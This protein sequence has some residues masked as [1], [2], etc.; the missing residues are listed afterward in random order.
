MRCSSSPGGK[1]IWIRLLGNTARQGGM[2]IW[3]Y[4]ANRALTAIE[5]LMLG[6]KLS[7]YHTG[8]RAY[9]RRV[10]E[11]LP[12]LANSDDFVFDNQILAQAMAFGFEIGEISCPT[13]YFP[14]ASSINFRRSCRYGL[15]VLSTSLKYLLW[16]S[17]LWKPE[18]FN[19]SPIHK[20]GVA[21][22][23]AALVRCFA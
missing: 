7:E 23:Q 18:I 11:V 4:V 8:Y 5:N 16:K 17:G 14:E 10:L 6:A 9:S 15:G 19:D 2:P 1:S 12:L 22:Y 3:K 21:W 13:H 20:L